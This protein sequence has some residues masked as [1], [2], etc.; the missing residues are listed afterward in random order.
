MFKST[1]HN[2]II[3]CFLVPAYIPLMQIS[4]PKD[5]ISGID[6]QYDNNYYI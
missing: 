5:K 2:T 3:G 1:Q 4:M 6:V